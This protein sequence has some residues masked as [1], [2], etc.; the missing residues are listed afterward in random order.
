M[1]RANPDGRRCCDVHTKYGRTRQN[2]KAKQQYT[3]RQLKQEDLTEDRK[4]KLEKTLEEVDNSLDKL[5]APYKEYSGGK[6][7]HMDIT[8][9]TEKVLN[10]LKSDGLQ[11]YIVGGS[12]RDVLL[13]LNNK[14]ID[15]EVYGGNAN[16]VITSLKKI[17]KVD[18]VGKAF[19]V[20]KI[21]LGEE[22]FDVSL[23]RRD[24]LT[25]EGHQGFDIEVDPNMSLEEASGRRDFTIN[26]L[27]Y[28]HDKE[29]IVDLH[30]GLKDL[31]YKKLRHVTDAFDEDPLRVLRGVQMA[32]RF[33]FT[34]HPDTIEK[35][36]TLKNG[37]NNLSK[38]RVRDE[39][40][41]L[42]NKGLTAQEGLKILKATEWEEN[43][44]GLKKANT[45]QLW[46][47][48]EKMQT[49]L[50]TNSNLNKHKD[51][52]LSACIAK[53]I[54][55]VKER[56]EFLSLTCVGDKVKNEALAL[57]AT[58][59][60]EKIN[61]TSM[62]HWARSMKKGTTVESW[63]ALQK[64]YNVD[65]SNIE[66][67]A[68]DAGVWENIEKD[69]VS[70]NDITELA[71]RKPGPWVGE[72]VSAVRDAQYQEKFTDRTSGIKWLKQS[73]LI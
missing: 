6:H 63:V 4:N 12:V 45:P 72:I 8:P 69:Y 26:A 68:K 39:F 65:V 55:N 24:S 60:P 5:E 19:G 44:P 35:A 9:K 34:L 70:G 16:Q 11:P 25:G 20:L 56:E 48:V 33:G 57:A 46:E 50:S 59:A 22:D 21:R 53:S 10:Q 3:N 62:R 29:Y 28:D 51:V 61:R 27:M 14:D 18:E 49:I 32:S 23:P 37:F 1:C 41:K 31:Q 66:K 38:E 58:E 71:N 2:L 13:G 47:K 54:E 43:F 17:G 52:Y 40:Q 64:S 30:D 7:Y 42:Y 36:K 73:G 67:T 15:I